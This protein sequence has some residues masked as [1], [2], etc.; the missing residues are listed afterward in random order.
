M[1]ASDSTEQREI[2][3]VILENLKAE[4]SDIKSYVLKPKESEKLSFQI[5]GYSESTNSYFEFY[6][7]IEELKVG[8]KKKLATDILKLITIEKIIEKPINK[9][10][11]LIDKKIENKLLSDSW[12]SKSVQLFNIEIIVI[13]I[14]DE[15]MSKLKI[16]KVRQR[17]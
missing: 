2:E 14:S 4:Y 12:L 16:A 9:F 3:T 10:I 1:H 13:D 17:R 15:L 5:D 11:V 6:A 7:G 8:Q